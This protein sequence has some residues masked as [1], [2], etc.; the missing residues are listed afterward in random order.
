VRP[1]GVFLFSIDTEQEASWTSNSEVL[2][3]NLKFTGRWAHRESHVVAAFEQ[4]GFKLVRTAQLT[5]HSRFNEEGEIDE[6]ANPVEREG[7]VFVV[8]KHN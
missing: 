4:N 2:D 5:G 6:G 8:Q 3:Y 1:G 7:T